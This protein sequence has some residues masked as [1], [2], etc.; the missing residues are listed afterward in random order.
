ML[1]LEEL[2][3]D[4]PDNEDYKGLHSDVQEVLPLVHPS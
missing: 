1:Q 3:L 2:L 4:E